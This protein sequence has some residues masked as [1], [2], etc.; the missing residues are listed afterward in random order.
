MKL[1]RVSRS[2]RLRA[3]TVFRTGPWSIFPSERYPSSSESSTRP[4]HT[5]HFP[6]VWKHARVISILKAQKDPSLPSSYRPISLLEKMG[7]LC[8]TI[9][10]TRILNQV[11]KRGLMR[12]DQFGFRPRHRTSLQLARLVERI[13]RN[14]GEKRIT[15][16]VFFDVA[17]AFDTVWIDGFLSKLTIRTFPCHAGW[18][19]AGWFDLPCPLQ[20]ACQRRAHTLAPRQATLYADDTL[21]IVTSRKPTLL[22][23]YMESYLNLQWWLREWRIAINVSK[24]T[25]II[26]VRDGRCFIQPPPV[27]RFGE[28]VL[29]V[30]T[31][32]YLGVTLNTWLT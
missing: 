16:A 13:T 28:P 29:W 4:P 6:A 24:I 31:T 3:Q 9:L 32:R 22:V 26:F 15:G 7:K 10:L 25:A 2:A 20:S 11:S 8:E 23:S 14:F 18:V 1:S 12:D 27:T 21:I 19:G 5:H 30:D 17:K